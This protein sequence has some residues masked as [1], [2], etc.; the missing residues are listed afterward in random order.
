MAKLANKVSLVTG[1]NSGI[2]LATAKLFHQEGAKVIITARSKE[3]F[4]KAEKEYG[5][6]FD[7]IQTDVSK[8]EDLDRLYSH[9]KNKYGKLD[10]LFANA[11]I[12]QFQA[13]SDATPEFFDSHYNTNV[14][15]LYFTISKALPLLAKGSSVILNASVLS[16]KGFAGSSVYSSTK[17]AVRSFAR[18][19]T[20][21]IPVDAVRFNVLS[22]GPIET[23]IYDKLGLSGEQ[24][25]GMAAGIPIKRFGTSEEMAKIALFLASDDSSYIV[26]AEIFADG[27]MGQV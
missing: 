6:Q 23:P 21:E 14:R 1:G 27:G 3:T 9:I 15:G 11:G 25:Q 10:L 4:E 2:G 7:V 18:S 17:A 13:T 12:A 22:P 5:T 16:Q 19:W 24:V 20:A 26:G 8:L